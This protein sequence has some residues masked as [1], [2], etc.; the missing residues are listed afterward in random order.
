MRDPNDADDSRLRP[1]RR[2]VL[3]G[4]GVAALATAWGIDQSTAQQIVD[5]TGGSV[6]AT[7]RAVTVR[8]GLFIGPVEV[9]EVVESA[10]DHL[11]IG[12]N[13]TPPKLHD[14]AGSVSHSVVASGSTLPAWYAP[15]ESDLA[16][17]PETPA[18]AIVDDAGVRVATEGAF[19]TTQSPS[20]TAM[21]R[22]RSIHVAEQISDLPTPSNTPALAITNAEGPL[23]FS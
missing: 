14:P 22:A 17:P 10:P 12:T 6:E 5:V 20:E 8:D 15:S 1:T 16:V 19:A 9:L 7:R 11:F 13:A 2:Q 3:G 4:L 21:Q 18:L 23:V